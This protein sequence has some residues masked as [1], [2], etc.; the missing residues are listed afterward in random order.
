MNIYQ[1]LQNDHRKVIALLDQLIASEKSEPKMRESLVQ[2]IRDELV[3]HSRAE[4]AVLYNSIRDIGTA[5]DVVAHSYREHMEAETL[6]R[7]LQVTDKLNVGWVAT[8]RKLKDA[9]E[10]HISEEEGRVFSA[11]KS[12]FSEEETQAMAEVFT[13]MKPMIK[14]QS[15][16]GNSVDMMVNLMP[17]RLRGAFSKFATS[18]PGSEGHSK[19]S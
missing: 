14:K 10:H 9:L 19:A 8:A 1:E 16:M 6:L 13:Q 7:G 3:P 15:F 2:Q 4:E 18:I 5:K 11:A 12:L 17:S